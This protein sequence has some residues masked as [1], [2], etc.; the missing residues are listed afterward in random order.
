MLNKFYL[1]L[2][3]II[4]TSIFSKETLD[5]V[6]I[7]KNFTRRN[8]LGKVFYLEDKNKIFKIED[9][10]DLV[11]IK[12]SDWTSTEEK[13][14]S[15]GF[16]KSVYWV[17]F[18]TNTSKIDFENLF[19]ECNLA[20]IDKVELFY[21]SSNGFEKKIAGDRIPFSEREVNYRTVVFKLPINSN[22]EKDFF[23]RLENKGP[24]KFSLNLFSPNEFSKFTI[25]D[26]VILGIYY[27]M[28]I[29]MILYNLSLFISTK[30][31]NYF[32]YILYVINIAIY[33]F[34]ISGNASQIL[35]YDYPEIANRGPNI[36]AN[37]SFI[38]GLIFTKIFL[39]TKRNA[40][41]LNKILIS[42]ITISS[43]LIL[44]ILIIGHDM[45]LMKTSNLLGL[46]MILS[47]ISSAIQV[48]R[49]SFQPAIY[50]LIG[51]SFLLFTVFIQIMA[52]LG[53][54]HITAEHIGQIGSSVEV[55]LLSFALSAKMKNSETDKLEEINDTMKEDE[56]S[57]LTIET[58]KQ[59]LKKP[60]FTILQTE[61][62]LTYKEAMVCNE[63]LK[64]KSRNEVSEIMGI[65]LNTLKKHLSEIYQKT[66]KKVKENE[67]LPSQEKLQKLTIFLNSLNQKK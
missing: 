55:I 22:E 14:L 49:K 45:N 7:D 48:Y 57:E 4:R 2:F 11:K 3:F 34:F 44:V 27:G 15:F 12:F 23:L 24:M 28:M 62:Q 38:T 5:Q 61:Y 66:I 25:N 21:K 46:V 10:S 13:E 31:K 30:E 39:N 9:I 42:L 52:N 47:I 17:Y 35:F 18:K 51:W 60:I 56:K 50:F 36:I 20:T 26:Q 8:L 6:E 37:L 16:T 41:I 19:L 53:A 63:L 1:I 33:Q 54:F 43:L 67:D 58:K 64:G 65:S 32:F 40:P 59:I 29:V